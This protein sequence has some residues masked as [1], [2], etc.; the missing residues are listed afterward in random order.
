M[1]NVVGTCFK[2]QGFDAGLVGPTV[3]IFAGSILRRQDV[4]EGWI[5]VEGGRVRR[6]GKGDHDD[7]LARGWIVPGLVNA[8]T[9]VADAFLR[10]KPDKPRTVKELVGPGG[11]KHQWL[12]KADPATQ[13]AAVQTLAQEMASTGTSAFIDFREG[14]LPGVQWLRNLEMDSEAIIHGRPTSSGFDEDEARALLEAVDGIG[15]SGLRD[16]PR[17]MLESW[18][19]ACRDARKPFA[20]HASE[21][22]RDPVDAIVSLEPSYVV[23]MTQARPGDFDELADARIPIVTCP[24]SNQ[25]FGM[26]PPIA[27]ML[28]SGCRLALGTDNGMLQD[29]NLLHEASALAAIHPDVEEADIL[30]MMSYHGRDVARLPDPVLETGAQADWI[31]LPGVPRPERRK[32]GMEPNMDPEAW[33]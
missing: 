9:H 22:K 23:H 5:E 7:A 12:A 1:G 19:D 11:W 2:A 32:P 3:P 28:E 33:K 21:D 10:D 6:W 17:K 18:G 4:I 29:G 13:G 25:W 31:V 30:R 27:Q 16:L 15:L 24:R 8:H 26:T 14:G 20:F